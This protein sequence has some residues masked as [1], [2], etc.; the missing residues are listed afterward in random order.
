MSKSKNFEQLYYNLKEEYSQMQKD[1][2][3]IYK[4]Y[5]STIQMLTDS[6]K[7]LQKQRNIMTKKLSEIEKEK[8]NLQIKNNDKIIDIQDLNKQ[9]EILNEEINKIK[10]DKKIK[11]TKIILLENDTE[12]FQKLIRQNE[13]IID[14]LNIKL[15][16]ALEDNITMQTE[17][18]IYRQFMG[19]QLM[20]KE[21][22]LK[23]IKNDM[24]SKNMM[25]NKLKNQNKI[26]Y[27]NIG[28]MQLTPIKDKLLQLKF[29]AGQSTANKKNKNKIK[30]IT[31]Q[32]QIYIRSNN[33]ASISFSKGKK[34]IK[35]TTFDLSKNKTFSKN[36]ITLSLSLISLV[37]KTPLKFLQ[38]NSEIST[39]KNKS[40]LLR[41]PSKSKIIKVNNSTNY[42]CRYT[43]KKKY[44]NNDELK[45]INK[46]EIDNTNDDIS[47]LNNN[48]TE[49]DL[50]IV[51]NENEN[52]TNSIIDNDF[53]SN[54]L[55]SGK[56][57]NDD[58][59][60]YDYKSIDIEPFKDV[61]LKKLLNS[62]K[63]SN[64]LDKLLNLNQNRQKKNVKKTKYKK[65]NAKE[66][67]IGYKI[68]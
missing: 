5:E 9:N 26:P 36:K 54:I 34:I 19:E 32:S 38:S 56:L 11:D 61:F 53:S 52:I 20:R 51:M 2:N 10:E 64:N 65:F 1:N 60:I 35:S 58:L 59:I 29:K 44:D 14:E 48:D 17:F 30:N 16:E 6:I 24:F 27:G 55:Y 4:E 46:F 23:D 13:A 57:L 68:K 31:N 7:E 18:E 33:Y 21:E 66:R 47:D 43:C 12:H 37:K 49:V 41:T 42:Y 40:N 25:I 28:N 62:K 67:Y 3:E 8:D 22:E 45:I 39:N 63:L 50:N 15:E